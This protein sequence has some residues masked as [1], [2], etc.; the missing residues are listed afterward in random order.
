MLHLLILCSF[1]IAQPDSRV[2]ERYT[3]TASIE[4][5]TAIR[6]NRGHSFRVKMKFSNSTPDTLS[7]FYHTC[8]QS[9]FLVNNKSIQYIDIL[10]NVSY[11]AIIKIA[12]HSSKEWSMQWQA[13]A[14]T[15]ELSFKM[16]IELNLAEGRAGM[17][18][19]E[20]GDKY[21]LVNPKGKNEIIWSNLLTLKPRP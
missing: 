7:L 6:D 1:L 20:D 11:P 19:P 12:P 4:E 16:G 18:H 17:Y 21:R 9:P 5:S 14:I 3:F 8:T 15:S 2:D 10:C 13:P